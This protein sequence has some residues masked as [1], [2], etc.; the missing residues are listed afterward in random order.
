MRR[1]LVL[2]SLCAALALLA[3]ADSSDSPERDADPAADAS[4]GDAAVDARD[5]AGERDSDAS[6]T[7]PLDGGA[8]GAADAASDGAS[9][10]AHRVDGVDPER[11]PLEGRNSVT[12]SGEGFDA[13]C[14]VR[15]GSTAALASNLV[16]GTL[17]E[18]TVPP[19]ARGGSV[20]VVVRCRNADATLSQGYTYEDSLAPVVE[21]I[22][23]DIGFVAG[24]EVVT[25]RGANLVAGER[26][27]VAFGDA[28]GSDL[29]FSDDGASLTVITPENLPGVVSVTVELGER[30]A[31]NVPLY[32]YVDFLMLDEVVPSEG[33]VA[34][35]TEVELR[36]AGLHEFADPVV[37]FGGVEAEIVGGEADGSVLRVRTPAGEAPGPVDVDYEAP[38]SVGGIAAGFTYVAEEGSGEG[39]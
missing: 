24:G 26:N 37:R 18:V 3:C 16:D 30:R 15:F 22:E 14:S 28:F 13:R 10:G 29:S 23:P 31:T 7:D 36:G 2:S 20:D 5:D 4:S 19:G 11:G 25:V 34:G 6:D 35:G 32:R 9:A 21:G 33:S 39:T 8:D 38:R 17:L 12:V 27:F 1:S